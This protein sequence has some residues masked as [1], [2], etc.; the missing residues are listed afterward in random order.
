MN[1]SINF[2]TSGNKLEIIGLDEAGTAWLKTLKESSLRVKP[3]SERFVLAAFEK[4]KRETSPESIKKILASESLA[5]ANRRRQQDQ[6]RLAA[7]NGAIIAEATHKWQALFRDSP[8][9]GLAAGSKNGPCSCELYSHNC[10]VSYEG[11]G[12]NWK[13]AKA[14]AARAFLDESRYAAS[15]R[16]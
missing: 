16:S 14:A 5:D 13:A 3:G 9:W 1:N 2:R 12:A 4:W 10:S 7:E 15:Y 11:N 6:Q 8:Q